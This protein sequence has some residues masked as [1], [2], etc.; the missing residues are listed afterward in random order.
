MFEKRLREIS[1]KI[2]SRENR[3]HILTHKK[4]K[5]E[6]YFKN[7]KEVLSFMEFKFHSFTKRIIY[8]LIKIGLLQLFLKKIKLSKRFG[9]VIFI[10]NK[11]SS[12]DLKK[13]EVLSFPLDKNENNEFIKSKKFQKK[14]AKHGFAPEVSEINEKIP[15]SKEE[16]LEDFE[17]NK[18][19]NFF[20][21]SNVFRKINDFYNFMGIEKISLKEY[22]LNLKR[23][24]KKQGI[25]NSSLYNKLN[26]LPK[27]DLDLL[28]T[29]LHGD[30]GKE[31]TLIKKGEIV[32]CDWNPYKGLIL[33]DLFNFFR[34]EN[35]LFKNKQ[36]KSLLRLYP[37]TVQRNFKLYLM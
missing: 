21:I 23:E 29:T 12:F 9:D 25:K 28:I 27:K 30:F 15:F 34:R 13:K 18:Y 7:S 8:F 20:H 16:L 4:H 1:K 35:N 6:I 33:N 10:G 31:N 19:V 22:I 24:L 11:I 32:F 3:Y 26:K 2:D 37:K 14:V 5:R 36:F 17:G